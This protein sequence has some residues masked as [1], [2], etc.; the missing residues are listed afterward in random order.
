[1][2]DTHEHDIQGAVRKYLLVFG[3]LLVGTI[4]TVGMY[5]IH[6]H[7]VAITIAVALFIATIKAS[8]VACYFMHL[9]D[10]RKM[11]YSILTA[12]AFFFAGLFVLLTWAMQDPPSL[13]QLPIYPR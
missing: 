7:S 1:M 9:I 12:T 3:A 11:I 2:S 6:I 13:T 5:Y 4:L 10:E 8:L